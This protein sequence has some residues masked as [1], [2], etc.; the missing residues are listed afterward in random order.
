MRTTKNNDKKLGILRLGFLDIRGENQS[1]DDL[2]H[3]SCLI[4]NYD[5]IMDILRCG[6]DVCYLQFQIDDNII[7]EFKS[8]VFDRFRPMK[9]RVD[10]NVFQTFGDDF[11]KW[12]SR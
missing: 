4:I 2:D 6:D 5:K 9:I 7:I 3:I 1:A 10:Y 8:K 11:T 12:L